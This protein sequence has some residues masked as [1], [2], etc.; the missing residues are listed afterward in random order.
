ML[1][2]LA[3]DDVEFRLFRLRLGQ[4][5]ETDAPLREGPLAMKFFAALQGSM[6][7]A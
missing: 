2:R 7:P 3:Q 6:K 4:M 1:R 5:V